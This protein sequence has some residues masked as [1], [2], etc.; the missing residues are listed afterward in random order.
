MDTT[1][2]GRNEILDPAHNTCFFCCKWVNKDKLY[3]C[4]TCKIEK[5]MSN[6]NFILCRDCLDLHSRFHTSEKAILFSP[7]NLREHLIENGNHTEF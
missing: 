6:Y 7:A 2:H 4:E 1:L 3:I 5:R